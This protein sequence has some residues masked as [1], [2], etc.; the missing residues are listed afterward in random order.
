VK[1]FLTGIIATPYAREYLSTCAAIL[2][3]NGF[4]C[5]TPTEGGWHPTGSDQAESTLQEDYQ[6]LEQAEAVVA[7]LDGYNVNDGVAGQIGSFYAL[8]QRD[9]SKKGILGILHDT[10]V[11]RWDWSAGARALNYYMLG[12]V[13]TRGQVFRSFPEALAELRRWAGHAERSPLKD[14]YSPGLGPA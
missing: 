13:E 11:A 4:E 9:G 12:C 7:V 14:P 6:A 2:R 10:R 5:Y 3:E 1:V 8:M